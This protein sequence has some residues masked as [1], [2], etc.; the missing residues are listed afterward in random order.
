LLLSSFIERG[1]TQLLL[2]RRLH[3]TPQSDIPHHACSDAERTKLTG[4]AAPMLAS[5]KMRTGPS[6]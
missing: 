4:G 6:G 1:V 3:D 2:Q 5:K